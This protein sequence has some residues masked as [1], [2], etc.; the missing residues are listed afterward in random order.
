MND[1]SR[2]TPFEIRTIVERHWAGESLPSLADA[3]HIDRIKLFN[4]KNE[5]RQMWAGI[6]NNITQ[7]HI[8]SLIHIDARVELN[9][10]DTAR[11]Q[12]CMYILK[13][14]PRVGT[15]AFPYRN[16]IV[17]NTLRFTH[18]DTEKQSVFERAE[19]HDIDDAKA[20]VA[21]FESHIGVTLLETPPHPTT[22][23]RTIYHV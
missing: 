8:R 6:E 2:L 7:S 20:A 13:N 21:T 10:R 4:F 1:V 18:H 5:N 15:R 12:L 22:L 23:E 11:V 3:F 17:E 16:F 9:D 19:I 14:I